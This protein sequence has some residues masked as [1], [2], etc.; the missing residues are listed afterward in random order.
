MAVVGGEGG[1]VS[2]GRLGLQ[3]STWLSAQAERLV[4]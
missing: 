4:G 2:V 1:D 3:E